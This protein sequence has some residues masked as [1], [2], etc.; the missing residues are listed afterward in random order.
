MYIRVYVYKLFAYHLNINNTKK[1][2]NTS[3]TKITGWLQNSSST[4]LEAL[5]SNCIAFL[6]TL[7]IRRPTTK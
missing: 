1:S 2:T 5:R 4:H 7:Y 3:N 6:L